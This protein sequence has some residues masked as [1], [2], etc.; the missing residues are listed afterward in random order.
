[1][2]TR[3][4]YEDWEAEMLRLNRVGCFNSLDCHPKL[5]GFFF[6]LKNIQQVEGIDVTNDFQKYWF[7]MFVDPDL[8]PKIYVWGPRIDK[9]Y[10]VY[11]DKRLCLFD[12][13]EYDWKSSRTLID[14]II[15][16]T[17]MWIVYFEEWQKSGNWY[18][19]EVDHTGIKVYE[20]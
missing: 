6:R 18:G 12:P 5:P 20:K 19:P 9:L 14:D 15:G 1:M 13:K 2:E 7:V 8:G 10:H 11:S 4:L 16:W 3:Y 17:Y